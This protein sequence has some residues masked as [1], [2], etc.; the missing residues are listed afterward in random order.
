MSREDD[1]K[2]HRVVL[3]AELFTLK[4]A[5]QMRVDG[6]G[7]GGAPV[8][9]AAA[10]ERLVATRDLSGKINECLE[11]LRVVEAAIEAG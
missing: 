2:A 10:I 6:E 8:N 4:A 1:L 3:L 7:A 9:A 11:A 5:W